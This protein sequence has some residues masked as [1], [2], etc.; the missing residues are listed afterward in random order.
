VDKEPQRADAWIALARIEGASRRPAE[1]AAMAAKAT[2]AA[3]DRADAWILLAM[4]SL[5]AGDTAQ[6]E[7]ALVSAERLAGPDAPQVS[8]GRAMLDRLQGRPE[9]ADRRLRAVLQR[10][11]G[12]AEAAQLLLANAAEHGRRAE[13]EAFLAGLRDS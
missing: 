8:L 9:S 5:D 10:N 7:K 11:P 6:A 12:F 13:A 1:G 3:P 4:L 2:A